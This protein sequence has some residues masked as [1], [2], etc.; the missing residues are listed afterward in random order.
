MGLRIDHTLARDATGTP[1]RPE[2]QAMGSA[3][4]GTALD[5]VEM[6]GHEA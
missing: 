2:P 1:V 6:P 4:V 5:G 3:R